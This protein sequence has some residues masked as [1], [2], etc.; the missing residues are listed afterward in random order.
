M[1]RRWREYQRVCTGDWT[2]CE[3]LSTRDCVGIDGDMLQSK[4]FDSRVVTCA[5][6]YELR[7][8]YGSKGKSAATNAMTMYSAAQ[9]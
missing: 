8:P 1:H 7:L 5:A 6:L 4:S 9:I 2:V 3:V